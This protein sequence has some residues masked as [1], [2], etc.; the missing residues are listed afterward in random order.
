MLTVSATS[1]LNGDPNISY[2]HT[3]AAAGGSGI[4]TWSITIGALPTGLWL[5]SN[6]VSGTPTANGEFS[7]TI[8]VSDGI[9]S[10]A[11]GVSITIVR[12]RF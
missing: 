9:C 6:T 1:L 7:F 10:V 5:T 12:I 11:R 3:L 4:Y 8:Q 2:S